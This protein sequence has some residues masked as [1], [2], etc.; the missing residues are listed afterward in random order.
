MNLLGM[1]LQ[2]GTA[3][4]APQ[5]FNLSMGTSFWTLVIF[6]ALLI[7]LARYAFPPIL[8]YAEAREQRI[9]ESLDE[10]RRTRD[11]ASELLERQRRDL[12]EARQQV[13]QIL[14]EGKQA[15]ERVRQ[16]MLQQARQEQEHLLVRAREEIDT[17]REKAV[18]A[19]RREAVEI[20]LAAASR[21]VQRRLGDEE[22]RRLVT[23]Y[24]A[25]I[26][27]RESGAGAERGA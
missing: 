21:L 14:A 7:V 11:E 22:D 4:E 19:V 3:E 15:A 23:G 2:A 18:E 5:V 1:V 13:Q 20:S 26:T 17:E 6:F 8:G 10:A 9:Q 25:D 16:E 24:L 12:A 27:A